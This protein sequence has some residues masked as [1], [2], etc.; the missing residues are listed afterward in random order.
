MKEGSGKLAVMTGPSE[1]ARLVKGA[2]EE[3]GV[4]E[5][6][7][8]SAWENILKKCVQLG[9]VI[10]TIFCILMLR[11]APLYMFLSIFY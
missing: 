5:S 9:K 1:N 8:R 3:K 2:C 10:K 4:K 7:R 6:K 11:D